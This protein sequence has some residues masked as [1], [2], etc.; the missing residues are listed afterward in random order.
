MNEVFGV[1]CY[2]KH[3][4]YDISMRNFYFSLF[5]L[6]LGCEKTPPSPTGNG[7]DDPWRENFMEISYPMN[8]ILLDSRYE[9][10]ARIGFL[11]S[12]QLKELSGLA[13]CTYRQNWLYAHNDG[14]DYNRIF[15]IDT[16]GNHIKSVIV[17]FSGNRDMEDMAVDPTPINGNTYIYLG[18]I[19]D[20]NAVYPEIKIY[21]IR[22]EVFPNDGRDTATQ[23]ATTLKFVYPDGPR[24]AE[25]LL[26]D[27]WSH[28]LYVFTKRDAKTSVYKA[29]YPFNDSGVTTLLK[30]AT[31][32]F[33]GVV[34]GDISADGKKVV[35][36]TYL[37]IFVWERN[38]GET[39]VSALSRPPKMLPY[40]Q[41]NQGEAF[42]WSTDARTYYT[43]SEG[44]N[45]PVYRGSKK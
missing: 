2:I 4:F 14:G 37:Q 33:N 7:G 29:S 10:M 41:E 26:V 25:A 11:Q 24:D 19:G 40:T 1:H 35:L 13:P 22:E 28:H 17:P 31:L 42:C 34:G 20:N 38:D 39:V 16:S 32:P 23:R 21:R 8:N 30:V 43:I 36:K 5:L 45:A 3:L 6:V 18:D 27:P 9:F 15:I 12:Q 44:V